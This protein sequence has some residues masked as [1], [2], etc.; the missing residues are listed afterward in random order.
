MLQSFSEF[1]HGYKKK[2]KVKY[3]VN[4]ADWPEW[5]ALERE[6]GQSFFLVSSICFLNIK[7]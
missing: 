4:R 5:L 7:I 6:K 1:S 3:T 2:Y